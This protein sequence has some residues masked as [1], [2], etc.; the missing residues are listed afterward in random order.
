MRIESP[1]S[2]SMN[3]VR[4]SLNK[5]GISTVCQAAMPPN[6]R[7]C[8]HKGT[9]AFMI[10]GKNCTRKCNFC[11]VPFGKTETLDPDEPKHLAETA[12]E[13][14]LKHVV[15]TSVTRDDLR[16]G[17]ASHFAEVVRQLN[18][19]V[20]PPPAVELLIPDLM[21][22]R[23]SLQ[24]ILDA[25]LEVLNH[26]VETVPR[27]YPTVRPEAIYERSLGGL[28]AKARFL[29]P[30]HR[31]FNEM[32]IHCEI[33]KR[34]VM[35]N[36]GLKFNGNSQHVN[37]NKI[38]YH[39]SVLYSTDLDFMSELL[40][41]EKLKLEEKSIKSTKQRVINLENGTLLSIT[42][43]GDFFAVDEALESKLKEF[44]NLPYT[45]NGLKQAITSLCDSDLFKVSYND[46]LELIFS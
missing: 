12:M 11:N 45:E 33:S 10:M 20:S 39:G 7:E 28:L 25:K 31:V 6:S 9:A 15:V 38:L 30:S 29:Q 32:G 37:K 22:D 27:L 36:K 1:K 26:N 44:E 16:D 17:G 24:I 41:P 8:F 13:L 3:N 14:K 2:S 40:T 19:I 42:L 5:F 18:T 23:D 43:E 34:N 21:G 35:L 4:N 46:M